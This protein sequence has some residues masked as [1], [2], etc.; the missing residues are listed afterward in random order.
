[1]KATKMFRAAEKPVLDDEDAG[2]TPL[3]RGD[4]KAD[5]KLGKALHEEIAT[6]QEMLYAERNRKV[7][8]VLQGVDCSGKDGTV[9][10][11]FSKINPMGLRPV[12]FD[13]PTSSDLARDF[14]WRVHLQV[15]RTGEIAVFNRSHYEDVLH[16]VVYGTLDAGAMA[17]RY[18]QIRDFERMLAESGTVLLKV[19]L[20]IS[21]DEQKRRLQDR[22]DDPDKHWKFDPSDLKHREQWDEFHAAYETAI[23]ETDAPH[24]PWYIVPAD[25]KPHRDIAVATLLAETL[26]GMHLAF[27]PGDP[28][29]AKLKV[30]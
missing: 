23:K 12:R 2:A 11:L 4:A 30:K 16:P 28:S 29:L 10:R 9:H 20:H 15:P 3:C 21:K 18:A 25:S 1:M 26:R 13:V 7:L 14:L 6:L 22:L 5:K 24:A 8:V 27:P 17:H 19:F